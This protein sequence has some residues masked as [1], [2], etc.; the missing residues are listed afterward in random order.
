MATF[1]GVMVKKRKYKIYMKSSPSFQ[2]NV[3]ELC[4]EVSQ[5]LDAISSPTPL[6]CVGWSVGPY[7]GLSIGK[8]FSL[9][10]AFIGV[11]KPNGQ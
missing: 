1:V 7:V 2:Y 5:F 4:F 8:R 10:L 3:A 11:K 9:S 6:V